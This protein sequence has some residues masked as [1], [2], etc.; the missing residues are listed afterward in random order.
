MRGGPAE[1][2][3]WIGT[4]GVQLKSFLGLFAG[5]VVPVKDTF[6]PALDALVSSVQNSFLFT[7]HYFNLIVLIAQ[8]A[9]QAVVQGR[10]SVNGCLRSLYNH[11]RKN[12]S[13]TKCSSL[14]FSLCK[15]LFSCSLI[16][17]LKEVVNLISTCDVI[18]QYVILIF[19]VWWR[20]IYRFSHW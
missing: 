3:N 4:Q 11:N 15:N 6:Y 17:L 12:Q 9:G 19:D 8:Q 10:L 5:L 20:R 2:G 16:F 18:T 7:G 14:W 1:F 13:D